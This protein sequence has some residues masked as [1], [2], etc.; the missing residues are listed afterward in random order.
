MCAPDQWRSQKKNWGAGEAKYFMSSRELQSV[1]FKTPPPDV[2][3]N[4][5]KNLGGGHGPFRLALTTPLYASTI[6]MLINF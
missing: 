5:Q 1:C 6:I 2:E 3:A 4:G